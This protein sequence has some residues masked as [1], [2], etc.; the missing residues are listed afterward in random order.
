MQQRR[1]AAARW[2]EQRQE[3]ATLDVEV[4]AVE[5]LR[6]GVVRL[7][8]AAQRDDHRRSHRI[9]CT[10]LRHDQWRRAAPSD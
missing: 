4:D 9:A 6:A 2:P 10:V 3:R 7:R 1:L 5:R 8:D